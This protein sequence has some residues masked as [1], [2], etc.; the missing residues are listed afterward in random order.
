MGIDLFNFNTATNP[1]NV[2]VRQ[3]KAISDSNIAPQY[4][5]VLNVTGDEVLD[6]DRSIFP[7][8]AALPERYNISLSS[9]WDAPFANKSLG[10]NLGGGILGTVAD[11]AAGTVGIGTRNKYQLAQVWQSSSPLAFNVDFVFN[12]KTNTQNDIRKKHIAMLKLVAPSDIGG[13][14]LKAPGPSL[15]QSKA[16]GRN[17]TLQLGTYIKMEN[18]II[19]D[20][21]SDI[22]TL[23]G[24]DGIPHAMTI[25]VAIESFFAGITT[26]DIDDMFSISN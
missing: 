8:I 10:D 11:A 24:Q 12:A 17:I 16:T 2:Q 19:K 4:R 3:N 5:V 15:L 21:S 18:V 9:Q 25:N 22:Q 13:G 14:V 23:C 20:V 26:Q 7:I 6:K 1:G